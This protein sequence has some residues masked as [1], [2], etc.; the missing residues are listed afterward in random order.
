MEQGLV[1][2]SQDSDLLVEAAAG[3]KP[4]F[5]G[6]IIIQP[7]WFERVEDPLFLSRLIDKRAAQ[8]I[9]NMGGLVGMGGVMSPKIVFRLH[10]C[11]LVGRE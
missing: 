5:F 10:R 8:K 2:T 7:T 4:R 9:M 3:E 6:G 1:L 11:S